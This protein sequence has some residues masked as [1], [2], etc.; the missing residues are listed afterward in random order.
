MPAANY[1]I[2]TMT[3]EEVDIA[4][5]WAAREGWNPGQQDAHCF[6]A[7]DPN[8]FFMGF[9]D[10][11]PVASIS[12]VRYGTRFGFIGC[13]IVTPE[14]RGKG[15]GMAIWQTALRY[16]AGRTIGLDGVVAQQDNYRKSGFRLAYR[17]SRHAGVGHASSPADGAIVDLRN[18]PFAQIAAY[19]RPFFPEDRSPFISNWITQANSHALG[20]VENTTLRGYGVLR[21]CRTGNKIG[22]LFADNAEYA[23]RLYLALAGRAG[24]TAPLFLDV[25]EVNGAARE[26]AQRHGM[27]QVFETARMYTGA[28]PDISLD[29]LFGVTSFE[30]G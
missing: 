3:A 25:P 14:H 8:G 10:A 2:S 6:R 9:V 18:L 16:L 17:N 22:P 15:Y 23:E 24:P 13:Y 19:D 30:L 26:L 1:Q 7:A 11:E 4:I 29:R 28:P 21:A 27:K 20:I 12:A 5:E